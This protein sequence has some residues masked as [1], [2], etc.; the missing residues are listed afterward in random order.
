MVNHVEL[1]GRIGSVPEKIV[2][3]SNG[4]DIITCKISLATSE[5]WIN[6]ETKEQVTDTQWHRVV[7]YGSMAE[8]VSNHFHK[9]DLIYVM[10]KLTYR[11]L[12]RDDGTSFKLTTVEVKSNK[13]FIRKVINQHKRNQDTDGEK[14][15]DD[16][17]YIPSYDTNLEE[18][19]NSDE[20]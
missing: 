19:N 13:G 3:H 11:N 7:F 8:Y 14:G 15:M 10:G 17:D 4:K 6:K 2:R 1:L 5:S 12:D 18:S 20:D 16:A 9:G